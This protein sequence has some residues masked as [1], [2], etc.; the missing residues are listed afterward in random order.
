MMNPSSFRSSYTRTG[1]RWDDPTWSDP[2]EFEFVSYYA[3]EYDRRPEPGTCRC[4]PNNDFKPI[5]GTERLKGP[6]RYAYLL[7]DGRWLCGIRPFEREDDRDP[8]HNPQ[9]LDAPNFEKVITTPD[10]CGDQEGGNQRIGHLYRAWD[11]HL[12]RVVDMFYFGPELGWDGVVEPFEVDP[13]ST[14]LAHFKAISE[15]AFD[16]T[17][18]HCRKCPCVAHLAHPYGAK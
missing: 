1:K 3:E 9:W 10:H 18:H 2:I 13:N 4:D 8:L 16:R 6:K 7:P 15:H 14:N 11:G 5:P 12:Y 17:F